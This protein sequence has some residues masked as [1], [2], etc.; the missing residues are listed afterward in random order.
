LLL[1]RA[2]VSR[3]CSV[4]ASKH[5]TKLV[6]RVVKSYRMWYREIRLG[7]FMVFWFPCVGCHFLV[8]LIAILA[9]VAGALYR[10]LVL[11]LELSINLMRL[12]PSRIEKSLTLDS[13]RFQERWNSGPRP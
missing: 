6:R 2:K 5:I 11:W 4:K 10:Q 3:S 13:T 1:H 12:V 7:W 8:G 9:D